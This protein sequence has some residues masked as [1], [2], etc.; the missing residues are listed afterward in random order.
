MND[1][2]DDIDDVEDDDDL[3]LMGDEDDED[4]DNIGDLSVEINVDELVAKIE[5]RDSDEAKRRREIRRRLEEI[6]EQREAEREL[7]N[8]FN[9]NLD[10][11][12]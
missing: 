7:D 9:F 4:T 3:E 12:Y 1:L 2:D 5:G 11:D 6:R 8:T 10:D